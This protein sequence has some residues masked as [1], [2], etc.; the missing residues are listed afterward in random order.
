MTFRYGLPLA[1]LVAIAWFAWDAWR[2]T[3][4]ELAF[5][6]A[7]GH[8]LTLPRAQL[9]FFAYRDEPWAPSPSAQIGERDVDARSGL[10]VGRDLVP[11]EALVRIVA[12]GQGVNY[13][14]VR[15]GAAPTRVALGPPAN[16]DGVLLDALE[17]PVGGA[18][19][20]VFGG[21]DRGVLLTE[22]DSRDDG[23]FT[24]SGVASTV[25]V[26]TMRVRK[27][28]FGTASY[29]W[30][31]NGSEGLV[32]HVSRTRPC[33]GRLIATDP[34]RYAGLDL[35]VLA[36]PGVGT[37]IRADGTFELD[38]VP[39]TYPEV[40]L[41]VPNLPDGETFRRT[42][43]SPGDEDVR[44]EIEP[45]QTLHG[46]V[47]NGYSGRPAANAAVTHEHGPRGE[48]TVLTDADGRFAIPLVPAG[49][50]RILASL[51]VPRAEVPQAAR[52][53]GRARTVMLQG[54]V[55]TL[56]VP[57]EEPEQEL[58]IQVD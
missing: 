45:G 26:L 32:V 37:K 3:R 21:G 10:V 29:D 24:V 5:V 36:L 22:A 57:G 15:L 41:V 33:R 54:S 48:E 35:R 13:G 30:P 55:Q 58:V 39:D 47:L 23:H 50:V 31:T 38:D 56:V 16:H 51:D 19:I 20:E 49:P 2:A 27:A 40:F 14:Y 4:A 8:A 34:T 25:Q 52:P 18:H 17:K 43:A 53:E 7:S 44:I 46:R 11:G 9:E 1:L 42:A 12:E 6:D 28:G